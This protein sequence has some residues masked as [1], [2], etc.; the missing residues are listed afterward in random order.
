MCLLVYFVSCKEKLV[1]ALSWL[2][3]KTSRLYWC[4]NQNT[5]GKIA[6]ILNIWEILEAFL[7][8]SLL[9]NL[10][11]VW[12]LQ[13][14]CGDDSGLMEVEGAH[15]ARTMSINA[16]ELKQL[17]QSKEES[18]ENL[19]L[20]LEKLVLVKKR[21]TKK[22]RNEN[23]SFLRHTFFSIWLVQ[24]FLVTFK[25]SEL[26]VG[27]LY[28]ELMIWSEVLHTSMNFKEYMKAVLF[29]WSIVWMQSAPW[30]HYLEIKW[31]VFLVFVLL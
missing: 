13:G 5:E 22:T 7:Q 31:Q 30:Y 28:S 9:S 3:L 24:V 19:F 18:P 6:A 27:C 1:S 11:C 29:E 21:K 4:K 23:S 10:T 2:I 26:S 12:H 16:A 14:C 15:S 17:L 8:I 25:N 20:E